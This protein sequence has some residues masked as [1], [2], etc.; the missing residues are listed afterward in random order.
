M[1]PAISYL[2]VS[3]QRSGTHLLGNLLRNTG[4]A[5]SPEEYFIS[6]PGE[7]WEERCGVASRAEYLAQVL[8]RGT[9]ANGVFGA[10]VMRN[11]FD[12]MLQLLREIPEYRGLRAA[13]ILDAVFARPKYVWMR[14]RD[15]V[16]QAISLSIACQTGVWIQRK[17]ET[18]KPRATP[19]FEFKAI[20]E[21]CNR[22]AAQEQAWAEYFRENQI[23][24][25]VLFYE[26]VAASHRAAT[27]RVLEFLGLPLPGNLKFPELS[28]E[29][30]A[31]HTSAEWAATYR[32]LKRKK[33]SKL[34]RL[35]R[36]LRI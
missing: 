4:I 25:L 5:G 6:R 36:R 35:I 30:Q 2:I 26:D 17:G 13:Q 21:W 8:E 24:P 14:R 10:V 16:A 3:V 19:R 12:R 7:T 1:K 9:T 31:N 11:Y 15:R 29:K 27:E 28:T 34:R 22:I 32:S 18:P 20:D 23:E 33:N